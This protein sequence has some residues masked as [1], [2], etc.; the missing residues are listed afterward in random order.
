MSDLEDKL[1]QIKTTLAE[2][3]TS[4]SDGPTTRKQLDSLFRQVHSLKAVAAAD[5][6]TDLSRA[7]HELESVLYSLRTG[8]STFDNRTLQQLTETSATLSECVPIPDEFSSSLNPQEKHALRQSLREGAKLF[9][10]QTSFDQAD[11]DQQFQNL[12]ARLS[13][14]GEVISVAPRVEGD[15]INFRI[16]YATR[17]ENRDEL[18]PNVTIEPIN[19]KTGNLWDRILRAGE[20][21]AAT[22]GKNINFNLRGT[23]IS[24]D[25]PVADCVIHLVRN[26]VH[27]GIEASGTVTISATT[28]QEQLT[29]TVTDDGR[30]IDKPTLERLFEPGFSTASEVSEISG[31]GVGL[32][33]VKTTV[34]A[35]GGSV[36]IQSEL[37]KG[38]AFQI[39]LPHKSA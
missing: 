20:S 33:V 14:D 38:S 32:D 5:G 4:S 35:R 39:T 11:F 25:D 6:L 9:L 31:R 23:E 24:L 27:H 30:G 2:L 16:I 26:A 36:Q 22:L 12:K 37:R 10:V 13:R 3:R 34:E 19:L 18:P 17:N 29:I 15:R 28:D 7:A 1:E 8:E 21:T